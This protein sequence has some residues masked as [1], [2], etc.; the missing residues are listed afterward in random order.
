[1]SERKGEKS[2]HS[3]IL[4]LEAARMTSLLSDSVVGEERW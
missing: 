2:E 3:E 4:R 1:M